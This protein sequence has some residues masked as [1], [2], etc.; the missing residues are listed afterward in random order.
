MS[1]TPNEKLVYSAKAHTTGGRDGGLSCTSDGRLDVK[2]SV[3]ATPGTGT[4]LEQLSAV[5]WSA[6]V[7]SV[8]K[9]EICGKLCR[10]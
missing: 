10:L 6:R 7:L 9:I 5:G 8:I 3:L 1:I 2:F 4:N